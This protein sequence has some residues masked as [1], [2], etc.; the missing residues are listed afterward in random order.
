MEKTNAKIVH[1]IKRIIEVF[2]QEKKKY[3]KRVLKQVLETNNSSSL[4][5]LSRTE[6]HIIA[7]IALEPQ[8]SAITIA[9]KM[10]MTRGGISKSLVT[11]EDKGLIVPYQLEGNNKKKYYKLT[12]L[13][14]IINDKHLEWH[15]NSE[16][17][18]IHC[19]NQFTQS[20]QE[21]ILKFF[22][23]LYSKEL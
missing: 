6:C 7:Y 10:K 15:H 19:I 18:L 13:G 23:S 14:Q 20:E 3:S 2:D 22:Q 1:E 5:E 4:K 8:I 16:K 9:Q 21:V 12:E 17:E 11:L